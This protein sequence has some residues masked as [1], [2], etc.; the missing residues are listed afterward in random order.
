MYE[1]GRPRRGLRWKDDD[2][3]SSLNLIVVDRFLADMPLER[4]FFL[5]CTNS[6]CVR[7]RHLGAADLRARHPSAQ[8]RAHVHR[9]VEMHTIVRVRV[10]VCVCACVR[11]CVCACVR[12]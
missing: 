4:G 10:R 8:A 9:C 1:V 5:F 7:R 3:S 6:A 12:V 11:V 2:E